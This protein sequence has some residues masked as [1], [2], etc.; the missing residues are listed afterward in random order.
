MSPEDEL[1][2][3]AQ[4]L[5]ERFPDDLEAEA[6]GIDPFAAQALA[7]AVR[8]RRKGVGFAVTS[9]LKNPKACWNELTEMKL[10]VSP[11]LRKRLIPGRKTGS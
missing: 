11:T 3:A 7:N 10:R 9:N 1:Y 2:D 5:R 8:P 6:R 4:I